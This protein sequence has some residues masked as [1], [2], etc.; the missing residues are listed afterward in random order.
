MVWVRAEAC[1]RRRT[2]HPE[3]TDDAVQP[4]RTLL[5]PITWN[6]V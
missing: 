2:G 4:D 1:E 3:T 6:N 5:D